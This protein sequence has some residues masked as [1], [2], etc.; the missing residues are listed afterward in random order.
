ML[1]T[2]M[3]QI[4]KQHGKPPAYMP[5]AGTIAEWLTKLLTL[6]TRVQ[7]VHWLVP[8]EWSL[9]WQQHNSE[10]SASLW[11]TRNLPDLQVLI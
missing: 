7:Q 5:A 4:R 2:M 6:D 1:V 9:M 10:Q 11:T 3:V 8:G